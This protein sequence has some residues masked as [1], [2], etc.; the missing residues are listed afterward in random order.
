MA[1]G[2]EQV[3]RDAEEEWIQSLQEAQARADAAILGRR[4]WRPILPRTAQPVKGGG[5]RVSCLVRAIRFHDIRRRHSI[6]L[7][8]VAYVPVAFGLDLGISILGFVLQA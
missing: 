5:G 8:A 3:L 6:A 2:R 4:L 1:G 7:D